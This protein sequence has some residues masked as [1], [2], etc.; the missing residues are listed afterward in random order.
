M[1]SVMESQCDR[2]CREDREETG[3]MSSYVQLSNVWSFRQIYVVNKD[4]KAA[5]DDRQ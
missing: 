3:S 4:R 2:E 5:E 1:Q